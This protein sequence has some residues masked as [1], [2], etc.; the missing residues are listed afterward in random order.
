MRKA[1][2]QSKLKGF[3]EAYGRLAKMMMIILLAEGYVLIIAR[4]LE[5]KTRVCMCWIRFAVG[6]R[7]STYYFKFLISPP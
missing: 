6:H 1:L 5:P 3:G 2:N 7:L 4:T